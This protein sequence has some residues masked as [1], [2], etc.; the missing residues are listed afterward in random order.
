MRTCECMNDCEKK[1][2]NKEK[3]KEI[4]EKRNKCEI[5]LSGEREMRKKEGETRE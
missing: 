4:D 5:M 1:R 3:R 2:T